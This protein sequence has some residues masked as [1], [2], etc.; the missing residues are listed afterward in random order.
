MQKNAKETC[1]NRREIGK[2][3]KQ[4]LVFQA[5]ESAKE[6]YFTNKI[7]LSTMKYHMVPVQDANQNSARELHQAHILY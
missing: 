1:F 3:T 2:R 5:H 6:R 7:G 4:F